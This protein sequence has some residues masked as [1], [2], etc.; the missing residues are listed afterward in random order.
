MRAQTK[1][2]SATNALTYIRINTVTNA[3]DQQIQ[4]PLPRTELTITGFQSGT[5][6]VVF[7][8]TATPTGDGS[9]VLATGDAV[10]SPWVFDYEGSPQVTVGLFKNG[11]TPT[12]YRNIQLGTS[13]STLAVSQLEDRVFA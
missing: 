9:N 3:T 5:D 7:D 6:V 4:Y 8:A 12:Y 13:N 2:A 11:Y 10:T 1:I